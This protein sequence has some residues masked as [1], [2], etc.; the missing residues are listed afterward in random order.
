MQHDEAVCAE[1]VGRSLDR[2][3]ACDFKLDTCL[4][5]RP[6]VWPAGRAEAGLRGLGKGP[7]A[8]V[9]AA[10]DVLAVEVVV[11]ARAS[12]SGSGASFASSRRE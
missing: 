12:G 2:V 3:E 4:Q 5:H 9:L 8:E 1:F 11:A 10:C 7:H 6:I